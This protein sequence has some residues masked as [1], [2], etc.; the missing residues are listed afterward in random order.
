MQE[1]SYEIIDTTE[2]FVVI[3]E[4]TVEARVLNSLEDALH[5][6]WV[7]EGKN[8]NHMYNAIN[9]MRYYQ[10]PD[11]GNGITH[12]EV[13]LKNFGWQDAQIEKL[14]VLKMTYSVTLDISENAADSFTRKFMK[15]SYE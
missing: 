9:P 11:H 12:T 14:S 1:T 13:Q 8:P 15:S 2:Q 5:A 7:L 10:L 3:K 4:K 6:I